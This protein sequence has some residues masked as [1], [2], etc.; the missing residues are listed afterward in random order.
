MLSDELILRLFD[1]FE[2]AYR[3]GNKAA[4]LHACFLAA[5]SQARLP[6][7]AADAMLQMEADLRNGHVT[8]LNKAFGWAPEHKATREKRERLEE[9]EE[10]V[11]SRLH[12]HRLED[13]FE[14]GSFS[15]DVFD[16]IAKDLGLERRVVQ[17]IY[18][19][20]A[21]EL[22]KLPRGNPNKHAVFFVRS[23]GPQVRRYGRPI[24]HDQNKK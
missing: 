10:R 20:H 19:K 4:L 12:Q 15:A 21:N 13:R 9:N 5:R 6:D 17:G 8:D 2:I 22:K 1:K 24:L 11:L 16:L 23:S 3:S 18:K 7:W 14:D